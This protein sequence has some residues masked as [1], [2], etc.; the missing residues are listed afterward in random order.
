MD[1]AVEN[2]VDSRTTGDI[3]RAL[4][5][6]SLA[7][8]FDQGLIDKKTGRVKD[9]MTH[10]MIPLAEAIEKGV[11]LLCKSSQWYRGNTLFL[12]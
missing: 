7:A 4:E 5:E 10:K 11:C 3:L 12:Y 9:P 2:I 1:A 8:M 6:D